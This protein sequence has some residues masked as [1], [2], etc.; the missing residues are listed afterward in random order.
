MSLWNKIPFPAAAEH[1]PV[2]DR[3]V[4]AGLASVSDVHAWTTAKVDEYRK[5]ALVLISIYNAVTPIHRLPTEILEQIFQQRW[6]NRAGLHLSHV[7]RRWR[8]ILLHSARFWAGALESEEI[9]AIHATHDPVPYLKALLSRAKPHTHG[10]SLRFRGFPLRVVE[11]LD[12]YFDRLVSLQVAV[13]EDDLPDRLWPALR[14]GMPRLRDLCI[15]ALVTEQDI[16][17]WSDPDYVYRVWFYE[18]YED[19]RWSE[20][21]MLSADHLPSL[22]RLTCPPNILRHFSNTPFRHLKLQWWENMSPD[23]ET[24]PYPDHEWI[25]TLSVFVGHDAL[26]T[27]ELMPWNFA[28][29]SSPALAPATFSL[30]R[31]LRI[32]NDDAKAIA[33]FMILLP[34]PATLRIHLVNSSWYRDTDFSELLPLEDDTQLRAIVGAVDCMHIEQARLDTADS[35]RNYHFIRC[36]AADFERLRMDKYTHSPDGLIDVFRDHARITR[37]VL[38]LEESGVP[39]DFHAF[40][41][42]EELDVSGPYVDYTLDLLQPIQLSRTELPRNTICPSLTRLTVRLRNPISSKEASTELDVVGS[43]NQ[44]SG[45]REVLAQRATP[46]RNRLSY[47]EIN[48]PSPT[49]SGLGH[50]ISQTTIKG[51]RELVDG[52]VIVKSGE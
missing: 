18:E 2:T 4:L 31:Y 36:Y 6:D 35:Y 20:L 5:L 22:I 47:L 34:F 44:C 17:T 8:D 25:G 1:L 29:I 51:L 38:S 28:E 10:M 41:Q 16:D 52:P 3:N 7:C 33:Q 27:L 30:L 14:C 23:R 21:F 12:S 48:L 43:G 50:S 11:S 37:L 49:E 39:I 40:P 9:D 42:L 13:G 46:Y 24:H 19:M 26:E 15:Q 45:L 32:E